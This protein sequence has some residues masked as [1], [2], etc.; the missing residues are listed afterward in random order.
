MRSRPRDARVRLR[1]A[2]E[3]RAARGIRDRP[4][5]PIHARLSIFT[6]MGEY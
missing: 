5:D 4:E 6:H 1:E 2:R 3:D